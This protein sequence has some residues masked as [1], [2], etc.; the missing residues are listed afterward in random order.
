[1]E[2]NTECV[3]ECVTENRIDE[4]VSKIAE[5]LGVYECVADCGGRVETKWNPYTLSQG[6]PGICLLY[7]KLMEVYPNEEK[8]CILAHDY[9]GRTVAGLNEQGVPTLSMFSGLAGLGLCAASVSGGFSRYG[10]LIHTVNT[11]ITEQFDAYL[12]Y[13]VTPQGTHSLRYD[14][15]E[16]I[17]GVLSYLSLFL[18]ENRCYAAQKKGLRKLVELTEE[19]EIAGCAV[20][21]WYIPAENQFS[22]AERKLYPR[23]NFNTS[24]SHGIAGPLVI[25]SKM[26]MEGLEVDGQ[27][28]AIEKIVDF[29]FQFCCNDGKRDFWKGQ[30]DFSEVTGMRLTDANIIRRDAWCYGSPGICYGLLAAGEALGR[31]EWREYAVRN[32]RQTMRDIRGIFSP[33][34]C[35][36]Y[37]GLYQILHSA[38]D[39]LGQEA[40]PQ[41]KAY[42]R[43]K[44][45]SFYDPRRRFGFPDVELDAAAGRMWAR[46]AAGLLGGAAGVCLALL[47]GEHP[48]RS[49]W[50]KAFLLD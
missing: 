24:L 36:G 8:W 50:K 7:G 5:Q 21:G 1:M 27:R 33:T 11:G 49:L 29:Y 19:I 37:A 10:K 34:F 9:L 44:I 45:L 46:D 2:I 28:A 32:I 15:I 16:G 26:L 35:H 40:F 38:E 30:L 31:P 47:E 4:V 41:E 13:V 6:L 12:P 17:S 42:L 20:P 14:V 39:L 25:L 18:Q 23:G 22:E 48:G 3:T 43:G